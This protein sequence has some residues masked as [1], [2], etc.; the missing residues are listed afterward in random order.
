MKRLLIAAV[1]LCA[2]IGAVSADSDAIAQRQALM[3]A[4]GKAAK[5]IGD[6]LKSAPFDLAVVQAG[7]RTFADAAAKA[8]GLFPDDSK[9]GGETRA[10]P[11]IWENKAD[12][13]AR[14]AKLGK[15]AAAAMAAITDEASF[16]AD[17]PAI[18][19]NCGG[20]HENYRAKQ[21]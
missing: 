20:C 2:G 11:T 13:D 17:A 14:F 7:L 19:K 10:L 1:A 12:V 16:K 4:N 5:A 18:F 21:Q 8:P 6:M 9:T 3:K 15:D